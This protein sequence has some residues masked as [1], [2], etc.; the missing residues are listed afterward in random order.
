MGDRTPTLV[1]CRGVGFHG[2]DEKPR[3]WEIE[4]SSGDVGANE[5]FSYCG[6]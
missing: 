6:H 4:R 2:K 3:D 5:N 1:D